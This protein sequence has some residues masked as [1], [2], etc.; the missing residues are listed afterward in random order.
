MKR[1][2]SPELQWLLER[3]I[4]FARIH[5]L[6][7]LCIAGGSVLTL[8]D[9]LII[10]WLIDKVFPAKNIRLLALGVAGFCA[11]YV[12]RL[13]LTHVGTILN[14]AAMQKMVFRVRLRLVRAIDRESALFH[15]SI[16][17]GEVLYRIDQDVSRLGDLVGEM[18]PNLARMLLVSGVVLVAMCILNPRLTV[19][20]LPLL[21][22]CFALQKKSRAQLFGAADQAQAEQ[23]RAT[24]ILQEHLTGIL[25]LQLL[26]RQAQHATQYARQIARCTGAQ[27]R[28]RVA[29]MR[30]TA[31]YVSLIVIG[32]TL[33]LGYGG[34]EVI[35]G[36]LTIGGLVAFYSY[37]AR[38]FEPLS[39]AADLQ[40]RTQRVGASIRR[41]FELQNVETGEQ[42][43]S[44][45]RSSS[46]PVL[47][48]REVS[49]AHRPNVM[50]IDSV[51]LKV[52][53]GERIAI[54]GRSGCGKSTIANLAVG[55]YRPA[56]G[57][58]LLDGEDLR[59]LSPRNVRSIV[60]LVPQDPIL[61]QGTLRENLLYGNPRAST[62][63]IE[64]ALSLCQLETLVRALPLGLDEQLGPKGG[65]LS[66][67]EKK[68][69]AVAR[70]LLGR[71]QILILDE[72]TS[73]LDGPT[74]MELLQNLQEFQS[75]TTL[76][77]ISHTREAVSMAN[78]MIVVSNG[79]VL[80]E[81]SHS[82]LVLRCPLYRTLNRPCEELPILEQAFHH[83]R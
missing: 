58:V 13:A 46:T 8:L 65:K 78:R 19:L 31:A 17:V 50:A 82:D 57:S 30:V 22:I 35:H 67:G 36:R 29:E 53:A 40:S 81:G 32:S 10:K 69:V 56:A 43:Q 42:A 48:F 77:L 6:T 66:G 55:L 27:V 18:L 38:L 41:I 52:E 63:D 5:L 64:C 26:N 79:R 37:V 7:L 3:A 54:V 33:I 25:Q 47:E 73:G 39:I 34:Y 9:P 24:A 62:R 83:F 61:F 28:Q 16:P 59:R 71:P 14:F 15:E 80:A 49:F 12:F 68:R 74:A 2:P 1:N 21:P 44:Q 51:N 70:A 4:P 72:A 45:L 23:G 20:V 11:V 76:I 60:S 75:G